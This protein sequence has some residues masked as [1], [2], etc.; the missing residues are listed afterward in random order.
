[1]RRRYFHTHNLLAISDDSTYS[2]IPREHG[3]EYVSI[4]I[5][6][7]VYFYPVFIY[8][9]YF[10]CLPSSLLLC[11]YICLW[12]QT[13]QN[14]KNWLEIIPGVLYPVPY[15]CLQH[16]IFCIWETTAAGVFS[17]VDVGALDPIPCCLKKDVSPGSVSFSSLMSIMKPSGIQ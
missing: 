8:P 7:F 13:E 2:A 12:G 10:N 1:M 15:L 11:L 3:Q 6:I 4:S 17:L 9:F 5:L 14:Q 16:P